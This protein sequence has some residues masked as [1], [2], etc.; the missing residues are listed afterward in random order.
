M[1]ICSLFPGATALLDALGLADDVVAVSHECGPPES[2]RRTIRVIRTTIDSRG[3]SEEIDRAVRGAVAARRPLYEIDEEALRLA[4]PDLIVAQQLCAVCAVGASRVHEAVRTLPSSPRL[5]FLHAHTLAESLED[6]R[7]LGRATGRLE[8]AEEILASCEARLDRVR[9]LVQAVA[10]RPGVFCV[11]WLEP[12]MVAGHWVP[13]MVELAGGR[14]LLAQAGEASRVIAP[15]ELV[16]ARPDALVLMPCGFSIA[17]TRAE[18]P[19]LAAQPWWSELPAVGS[20]HVYLVHGP[21]G[22]NRPGPGLIDGVELLAHLLY[23][24]LTQELADAGAVEPHGQG[25]WHRQ[26]R[27]DGGDIPPPSLGCCTTVPSTAEGRGA[28]AGL[29]GEMAGESVSRLRKHPAACDEPREG[30]AT[31]PDRHPRIPPRPSLTF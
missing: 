17:R 7:R 1:R 10:E 16:E 25:P 6:V 30:A 26:S 4:A 3:S 31:D 8:A 20:N 21:R 11:E 5:L 23:P 28:M 18:L 12:L 13:E 19:R 15:D 2:A 14:N 9:R 29:K 22:F 24:S 27:P